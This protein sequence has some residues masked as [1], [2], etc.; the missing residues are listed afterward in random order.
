MAAIGGVDEIADA[1]DDELALVMEETSAAIAEGEAVETPDEIEEEEDEL[2]VE[3]LEPP[4][5]AALED[6]D[7]AAKEDVVVD[8]VVA[9]FFLASCFKYLSTSFFICCRSRNRFHSSSVG[10]RCTRGSARRINSIAS[11]RSNELHAIKAAR[12]VASG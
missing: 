5:A 10:T 9:A 11:P 3:E 1:E 12:A 6:E 7:D 2:E 4:E 8:V